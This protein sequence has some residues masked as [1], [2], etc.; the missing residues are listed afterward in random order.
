MSYVYVMRK[1]LQD[2]V[3]SVVHCLYYMVLQKHQKGSVS[4]MNTCFVEYL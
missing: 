4:K 3:L 2:N 1:R